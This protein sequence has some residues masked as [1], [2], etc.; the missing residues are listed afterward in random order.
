MSKN[1]KEQLKEIEIEKIKLN[2]FQMRKEVE[3]S[4][5]EELARS[6][7]EQGIIQPLII[8][9]QEKGK[10][11]LITGER[12]LRAAKLAG[13][14]KVPCLVR[15][16]EKKQQL[17]I[18]LIENIQREDLNPIEEA[19]AYQKLIEKFELT[20]EM[21]AQR[22]GKS[23]EKIANCLRL[24]KL[25]FSIQRAIEKRRISEGHAKVILQ[26]KSEEQKRGLLE[27]I[28]RENLSVRKTEEIIKDLSRKISKKNEDLLQKNLQRELEE[29]FQTKVILK[30]KKE[31]GEI[32]IY[33]YSEEELKR[34]I[35]KVKVK[36][37]N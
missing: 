8:K 1:I 21:I 11:E 27:K 13:L 6:I 7:S 26:I 37:H 33:F 20:Q 30:K 14:E 34:I 10:Y 17:E 19:E 16:I 36:S 3:N 31:G 12:R 32:I 25:P 2:P 28:I 24:L 5:L 23:R 35:D 29:I 18:A 9:E 22:I 15:K 4:N